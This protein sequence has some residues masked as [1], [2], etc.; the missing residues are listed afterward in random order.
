VLVLEW[1]EDARAD[2]KEIEDYIAQFNPTAAKDLVDTILKGAERLT[3]VPYGFRT[4]RV[5]GTREYTVHPNYLLIYKVSAT[6]VRIV[7]VIHGKRQYP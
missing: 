5:P 7:N 6:E 1:A 3:E 4:G 2:L